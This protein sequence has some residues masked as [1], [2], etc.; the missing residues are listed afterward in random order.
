[1]THSLA[2]SSLLRYESE[3]EFLS[4]MAEA[5][6]RELRSKGDYLVV[7]VLTGNPTILRF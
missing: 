7:K 5:G 4:P 1:M 3:G 6:A 2:H